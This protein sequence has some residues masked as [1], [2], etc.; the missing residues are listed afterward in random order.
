M[1][2]LFISLIAFFG[3]GLAFAQVTV[4]NAGFEEWTDN[5]HPVGWN[6]SFSETLNVPFFGSMAVT[7]DAAS[8]SE[9]AHSGSAAV[10]LTAQQVNESIPTTM[11]P[12]VPGVMQLG[13]FNT[14]ALQEIDFMSFDFSNFDVTEFVDGGIACNELPLKVT[15]WVKYTTTSDT[16]RAGVV[17]TRWNNGTRQTVA[18]G[19]I[20]HPGAI[21]EYT[22]IEIPFTVCG[23]MEGIQPD[24]INIIFSNSKL[25]VD[26]NTRLYVDDVELVAATGIY[27]LSSLPV[28]SVQP[29]PAT[30]VVTVI[31]M[32]NS[33]YALRMY[34]TN[35]KLVRELY[36]LQGETRVDVS[37]LTK[38]IYFLQVK[39]GD[40]VKT[41]K[42]VVK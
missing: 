41:Q 38:G 14:S 30:E 11:V 21:N 23:G 1:K 8:R 17:A 37:T 35:G 13:Q 22:Q 4:P 12:L 31:P 20:L 5:T 32:E 40:N 15:A 42:V 33:A 26:A 6:A 34:D 29:N 24:T 2:K 3:M 25:N 18:Q 9:D 39:Q 27:D 7:Y 10:M 16:L 19:E 36:N 28:F